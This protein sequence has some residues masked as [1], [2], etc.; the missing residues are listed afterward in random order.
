MVKGWPM[1]AAA[2]VSMASAAVEAVGRALGVELSRAEF[3]GNIV[4]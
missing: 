1:V 2:M 4:K 3:E